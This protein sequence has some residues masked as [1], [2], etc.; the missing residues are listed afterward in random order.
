M[1]FQPYQ[2]FCLVSLVHII[3]LL[4]LFAVAEYASPSAAGPA[5]D[6]REDRIQV[7]AA[8]F[9]PGANRVGAFTGN[10]PAAAVFQAS[11]RLGYVFLTDQ[12]MPI[13]AYSGKPISTLVGLSTEGAITG[14]AIVHHEEPILVVGISEQD[15]VRHIEQYRGQNIAHPI[16]IG[17]AA[18]E[19]YVTVDGI[20]GAT[21]TVMVLN[22]SITRAA[23]A[24]AAS[25]GIPLG[26]ASL[27]E[28]APQG[29]PPASPGPRRAS[30]DEAPKEPLWMA[31]WQQRTVRVAVLVAGLVVLTT[32]LILQD[33]LARHPSLLLRVRDA[34]LVYTLVFIGWYGLAQLSVINVFTFTQAVV[35]DFH[36]DTFLIDPLLFIL[37]SFVALTLLLWGRGVF[38]GWLCPFGALQ[39]LVNK[40]SRR[41]GL[42]QLELPAVLH[43]RL[44]AVKYVLLVLLF[45]LSLHSVG[46]MARFAEVEPFKTAINMHFQRE[47]T[48]LLYAGALVL[49][50][51]FNGK[52]FCKYLCVLGAALTFPSRFRIFDWLR[53]RRECGRPCQTC[54][55]ECPSQAI[56]ATGEI[57]PN[58]CH[59][60]LD[61]QV[62]Y[63]NAYKCPPLVEK[64]KRL[65]R[66]GQRL[67]LRV[68]KLG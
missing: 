19:G 20:S 47:W 1:G 56:R 26:A 64:R 40:A 22:A 45:G 66:R 52:F 6:S 44:L 35:R 50:S 37:W 34:F 32:V 18:R 60:C 65:E 17:G 11:R 42:K 41:L 67:R 46:T 29:A 21:I 14:L 57:N 30:S 39:E 8:Q 63:W 61:C 43:E 16:K 7:L 38:C 4:L 23:K 49:V 58:E 3:L 15:L 36:W 54:A 62:T 13:P 59:Y 33:W 31:V 48:F 55:A 24:V 68:S 27:P 5:P 9:F 53:R 12:V 51:A 10:P 28:R 25:R 2:R